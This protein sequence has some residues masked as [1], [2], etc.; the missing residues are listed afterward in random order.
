VL[1]LSHAL[2]CQELYGKPFASIVVHFLAAL[3]IHLETSRLRT[4]A[5]FSPM[6]GS[7]VYCVRALMIEIFLLGEKRAKQGAAETGSFLK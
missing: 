7:L 4:T 5:E 2:I 6:L 3:S 1:R